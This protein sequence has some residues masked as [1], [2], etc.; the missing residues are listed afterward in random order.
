MAIDWYTD[1]RRK[2]QYQSMFSSLCEKALPWAVREKCTGQA[3]PPFCMG[4]V[5]SRSRNLCFHSLL[6]G[7]ELSSPILWQPWQV[8]AGSNGHGNSKVL[9]PHPGASPAKRWR[10]QGRAGTQA[11]DQLPLDF[12]C[13]WRWARRRYCSNDQSQ[14]ESQGST[15]ESS[16]IRIQRRFLVRREELEDIQERGEWI[17]PSSLEKKRRERSRK[18]G[19]SFLRTVWF[20]KPVAL[21]KSKGFSH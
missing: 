16:E 8:P 5:Q 14:Q 1:R 20:G 17:V 4:W 9:S 19:D 6:K 10:G 21:G 18:A 15:E 11:A 2:T 3:E 12:E 7:P 13:S